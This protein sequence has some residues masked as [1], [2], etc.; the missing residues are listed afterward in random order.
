MVTNH[1]LSSLERRSPTLILAGGGLLVGH[2]VVRG[3][4]AFTDVSTPP[5]AFGPAGY[6]LV[7]LGLLGLYPAL[8]DRSPWLAR[9]AALLAVVPALDYALILLFGFGELAGISSRLLDVVPGSVFLP[10]HQGSMVLAYGLAGLGVLRTDAY[11]Q[12]VG[13]LLLAFPVLMFALM[14]GTTIVSNSAA[15][16]FVGGCAT[17]LLHVAIGTSLGAGRTL[18]KRFVSVGDG[19]LG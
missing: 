7:F 9:A 19:T 4:R 11:P 1:G 2:A 6:L 14:A 3:L 13:V 15:L 8:A 5:D 10:I 17:A 16:S 12:H 18:A